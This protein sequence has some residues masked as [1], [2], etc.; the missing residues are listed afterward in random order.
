MWVSGSG[1]DT[2]VKRPR[3]SKLLLGAAVACASLAASLGIAAASPEAESAPVVSTNPRVQP[4]GL[5]NELVDVVGDIGEALVIS[6]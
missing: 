2:R 3:R 4:E 6:R 5:H 1:S